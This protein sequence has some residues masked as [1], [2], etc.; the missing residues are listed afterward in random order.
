MMQGGL[1][2]E[3]AKVEGRGHPAKGEGS[4]FM[5]WE[6][7]YSHFDRI[8]VCKLPPNSSVAQ[9]GGGLHVTADGA[10]DCVAGSAGGCANHSTC[11]DNPQYR[12]LVP[13]DTTLHIRL[14]QRSRC[15]SHP[16]KWRDGAGE[17]LS[18]VSME[19]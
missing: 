4:F 16:A 8:Y 6:D 13:A 17:K 3:V 18:E 15:C 14:F 7:F 11:V 5:C 9:A 10:W 1:G 12:L 2:H 19:K